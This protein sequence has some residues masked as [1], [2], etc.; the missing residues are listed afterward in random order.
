MAFFVGARV[1]LLENGQ[2]IGPKLAKMMM[3]MM[4]MMMMAVMMMMMMMMM[5]M[6]MMRG[7]GMQGTE[8]LLM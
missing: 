3:M 6:T 4:M 1:E 5:M 2:N 8:N 7:M